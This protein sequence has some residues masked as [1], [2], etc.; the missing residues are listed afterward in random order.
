MILFYALSFLAFCVGLYF[1]ARAIEYFYLISVYGK[2]QKTIVEFNRKYNTLLALQ[3]K[4]AE[5]EEND[6]NPLTT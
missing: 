4:T 2:S 3:N 5:Q 1:L 6:D